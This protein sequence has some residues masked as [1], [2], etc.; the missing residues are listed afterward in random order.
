EA[1][2]FR[3]QE[4][5]DS[6]VYPVLTLPNEIVS[7]IFVHS[8]PVYPSPPPISGLLSPT[9]LSHICRRWRQ[10][11]LTTPRLW[12]AISLPD[13]YSVDRLKVWLDLSGRLP[14][15]I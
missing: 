14:L 11:A 1:E 3:A 2:K 5:L 7:E 9:R 6:Y 4:R 8:L 15:S 10:V 12:R 13:S